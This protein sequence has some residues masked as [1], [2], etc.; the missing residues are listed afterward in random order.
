[1]ISMMPAG[2]LPPAPIDAA[3]EGDFETTRLKT[4]APTKITT[5]TPARDTAMRSVPG[6]AAG[7]WVG[8]DPL[9]STG[10][11]APRG[12]VSRGAGS[13]AGA[14]AAQNTKARRAPARCR[15]VREGM[16]ILAVRRRL[17]RRVM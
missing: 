16:A 9:G 4:P 5:R 3:R 6:A 8:I 2:D 17:R 15:W 12:R 14:A 11:A 13:W 10:R 7:A 1:M